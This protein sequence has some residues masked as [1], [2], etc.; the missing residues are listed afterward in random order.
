MFGERANIPAQA[1]SLLE[2]RELLRMEASGLG[3]KELL[4]SF[5]SSCF[6]P[7][8]QIPLGSGGC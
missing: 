8:C 1:F 6:L 5:G 2:V 7:F 4:I 3:L